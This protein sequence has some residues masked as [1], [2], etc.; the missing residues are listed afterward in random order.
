VTIS[1]HEI[2]RIDTLDASGKPVYYWQDEGCNSIL[3]TSVKVN[4]PGTPIP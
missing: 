2:Y 4:A 3:V 1:G